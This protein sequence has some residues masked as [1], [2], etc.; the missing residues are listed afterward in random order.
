MNIEVSAMQKHVNLV[1]FVKSVPTNIYLQNLASIQP[2][3]S[4]SKFGENYS[5]LFT[6]VLSL[7]HLERRKLDRRVLGIFP[8]LLVLRILLRWFLRHQLY[9]LLLGLLDLQEEE[10]AR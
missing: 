6:G 9:D 3:T 5:I 2:R 1:D 4:P 8:L 7:F 10:G